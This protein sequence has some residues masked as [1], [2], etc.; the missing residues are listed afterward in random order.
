MLIPVA[1]EN[2]IF[3]GSIKEADMPISPEEAEKRRVKTIPKEV[4]GVIDELV[5]NNLSGIRASMLQE[6]IVNALIAR[7]LSRHIDGDFWRAVIIA[8]DKAGWDVKIDSPGF[9]E[10]YKTTVDFWKRRR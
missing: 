7:N 3:V 10:S 6:T 9:N 5:V 8:Y 4:F 1:F 2:T